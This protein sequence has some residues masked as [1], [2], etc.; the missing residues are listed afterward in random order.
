MA[1]VRPRTVRQFFTLANKHLR[2]ELNDLARR[3]DSSLSLSESFLRGFN[4]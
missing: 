2:W 3:S 4:N 1:A